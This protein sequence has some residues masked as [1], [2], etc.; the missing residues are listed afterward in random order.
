MNV[1]EELKKRFADAARAYAEIPVLIGP[2]WLRPAPPGG[3]NLYQYFGAPKVA[4][5]LGRDP[6]RVARGMLKVM[7]F[8]GLDLAGEVDKNAVI[9]ISAEADST[10]QAP[11]TT[12]NQSQ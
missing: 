2:K 6:M 5:A 8:S 10:E 4:K 3:T 7:D 1:E 9:H 11:D 12:E